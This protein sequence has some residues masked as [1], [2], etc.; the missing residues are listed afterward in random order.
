MSDTINITINETIELVGITVN[1]TTEAVTIAVT[2]TI[3]AVNITVAEVG[4]KGD[5]G[6]MENITNIDG[7]TP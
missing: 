6:E 3:E 2:E 4:V 1:E 5:P 7:G